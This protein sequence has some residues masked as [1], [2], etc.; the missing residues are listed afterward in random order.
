MGRLKLENGS[1][2]QKHGV[3]GEFL[4]LLYL[5]LHGYR[6]L[7]R[8]YTVGH[9]EIDL[10]V[11]KKDTV[12]FIEVKSSGHKREIA[13]HSRVDYAKRNKLVTAARVYIM[14]NAIKQKVFR[15]DIVEVNFKPLRI[16]HIIN[17]FYGQD[18]IIKKR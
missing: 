4:A 12:A 15:F 6:L 1:I 18:Y 9:K 2:T 13:L 5:R 10:I 16:K 14:R 11:Q 17:A 7:E 8:N 3:L